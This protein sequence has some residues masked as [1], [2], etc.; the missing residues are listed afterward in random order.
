MI[1]FRP[2][3]TDEK[4][5]DYRCNACFYN[6]AEKFICMLRENRH[7]PGHLS[8]GLHFY[9]CEDCAKEMSAALIS[10]TKKTSPKI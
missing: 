3:T 7:S 6:K 1:Q 5:S 4:E 2:V 8:G 10:K 9:L